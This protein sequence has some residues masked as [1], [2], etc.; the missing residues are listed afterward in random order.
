M[1]TSASQAQVIMY[2]KI[3]QIRQDQC[4]QRCWFYIE[5][6]KFALILPKMPNKSGGFDLSPYESVVSVIKISK[7]SFLFL[8]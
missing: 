8:I 4:K 1:A 5:F 7:E 3:L 2:E 6:Y